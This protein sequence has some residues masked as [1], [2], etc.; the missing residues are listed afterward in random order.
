MDGTPTA[1]R[2]RQVV[3]GVA[4]ALILLGACGSDSDDDGTATEPSATVG[5]ADDG[6]TDDVTADGL[7]NGVEPDSAAPDLPAD[8]P[9]PVPDGGS[10]TTV[11]IDDT[12]GTSRVVVVYPQDALDGLIADYDAFFDTVAGD[13]ERVPLTDGLASW[14]NDDA[15]YSV[16]LNAQNPEVQVTLQTGI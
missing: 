14:Q 15:G 11:L 6:T 2:A 10:I 16:V 4:V 5:N 9:L 13:T 7:A 3:V 8:Y 12:S 1:G